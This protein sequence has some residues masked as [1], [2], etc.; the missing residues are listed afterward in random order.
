MASL[1]LLP[2]ADNHYRLF[3]KQSRK[4]LTSFKEKVAQIKIIS[5]HQEMIVLSNTEMLG[6]SNNQ[7]FCV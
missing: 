6:I 2:T 1:T 4:K 5:K 3:G 7:I